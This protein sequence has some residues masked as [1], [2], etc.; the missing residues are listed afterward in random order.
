MVGT[1]AR[2]GSLSARLATSNNRVLPDYLVIGTQRGGTTALHAFL[3]RHPQVSPPFRKEVQF[4][5]R[6]YRLGENWYRAHF[7][8]V[9]ELESLGRGATTGEATANYLYD[10]Q[11]PGRAHSAIP[12]A[13]L[14]VLLRNPVDRA[15][16]AWRL[17][18][19]QGRESRTFL[20]AVN[21]ELKIESA[22]E[23]SPWFGRPPPAYL[24][25]GRYLEQLDRWRTVFDRSS[26]L[27]LRSEDLFAS[28][29]EILE[30]VTSFLG[31]DPWNPDAF[32]RAY[33]TRSESLD[34]S[35]RADLVEYFAPHNRALEVAIN[36][37]FDWC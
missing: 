15:H 36:R 33:S 10:V 31:I 6:F 16:S 8:K 13:Q 30:M 23:V 18:K 5:D 12:D 19:R 26:F 21:D 11:A 32:R 29:P 1:A 27:I 22:A 35:L 24:A 37:Q 9:G 4:F 3:A 14:I 2:L 7:P 34:R 25:R 28:P 20:H 17:F